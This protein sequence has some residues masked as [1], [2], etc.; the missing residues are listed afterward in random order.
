[1]AKKYYTPEG[2]INL[3]IDFNKKNGRSPTTDDFTGVRPSYATFINH[4]GSW[5]KALKT[6][7]LKTTIQGS[8]QKISNEEIIKKVK[9][10]YIKTN[11]SP[12]AR[13]FPSTFHNRFSKWNTLLKKA[14][15]PIAK[16]VDYSD[17]ELLEILLSV[18]KKIGHTP[19]RR[20]FNKINRLGPKSGTYAIHFGSWN[21]ALKRIDLKIRKEVVYSKEQ[22]II[23]LKE[24]YKKNNKI[25]QASDFS[26][27]TTPTYHTILNSLNAKTWSEA[28]IIAGFEK[29]ERCYINDLQSRWEN[30]VKEVVKKIY[31]DAIAK[32]K[33][34]INAKK[35]IPN[36][37]IPSANKIIDAKLSD[38]YINNRSNKQIEK[39]SKLTT[40]IE[41]WCL[42]DRKVPKKLSAKYVFAEEI[43]NLLNNK[44]EH[45][46]AERCKSFIDMDDK[47]RTESGMY[48]KQE[49]INAI[50][51]YKNEFGKIPTAREMEKAK[52]YPSLNTYKRV[53]GYSFKQLKKELGYKI[54]KYAHDLYTKDEIKSMVLKFVSEHGR[55]PKVEEFRNKHGLPSTKAI[56]HTF[57]SLNQCLEYCELKPELIFRTDDELI[58]V[59]KDFYAQYHR[60]PTC[61]EFNNPKNKYPNAAV[62][63]AHFGSWNSAI[64]LAG[65]K[66]N[67][68]GIRKSI[69][70]Q[71][72]K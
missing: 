37:Y 70:I 53:L 39:Y 19:K 4:F 40:D 62:Y 32:Y 18:T 52:S 20:E 31:P 10:Y 12:Q 67:R 68:A 65:L 14:G 41:L 54:S 48:T 42:I 43:Y 30:F 23:A 46:L 47:I 24:F 64:I 1:M 60:S 33:L 61:T 35:I 34:K 9:E 15:I 72:A 25:P 56:E 51:R 38:Y 50:L 8:E 2:L 5:N 13:D 57:G 29:G 69:R 59:I 27:N 66:V 3:L 45:E 58:K 49:L 26:R 17:K 28:L 16:R 55:R 63:S 11:K 44:K 6:A 7:G 71:K 36:N 22:T 21:N